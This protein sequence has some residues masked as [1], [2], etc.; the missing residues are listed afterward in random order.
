MTIDRHRFRQAPLNP[1]IDD[2]DESDC[3]QVGT[4]GFVVAGSDAS[5]VFKATEHALDFV[6]LPVSAFLERIGFFAIAFV[7]YDGRSAALFEPPAQ[8]VCIIGL[9]GKQMLRRFKRSQQRHGGFAIR[10]IARRKQKAYRAA[11]LVRDRVDFGGAPATA[12]ADGFRTAPFLPLAERC[13]LIIVLSM[14]FS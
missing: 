2:S 1:P 4:G 12:P 10:G 3:V 14:L 8:I 13:A 5:G 6:A 11:F 9:V 7:G